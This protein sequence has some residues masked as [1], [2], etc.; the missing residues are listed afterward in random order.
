MIYLSCPLP[1]LPLLHNFLQQQLEL[2]K[3]HGGTDWDAT[4]V[5]WYCGMG[6]AWD[7]V[8]KSVGPDRYGGR[9][10]TVRYGGGKVGDGGEY[11]MWI[12]KE[13]K[14]AAP[15]GR[16]TVMSSSH[17]EQSAIPCYAGK[18]PWLQWPVV[19]FQDVA[20]MSASGTTTPHLLK[21][22]APANRLTARDSQARRDRRFPALS[23]NA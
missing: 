10:K 6:D 16:Q 11:G 1:L 20:L 8:Q 18:S 21:E 22:V 19:G 5:L 2:S 7:Y 12:G 3:I 13:T 9:E 15:Q 23:S 17:P 14:P 4:R